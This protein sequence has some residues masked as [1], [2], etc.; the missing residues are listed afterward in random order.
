MPPLPFA[1][2][3]QLA[4]TPRAN[5]SVQKILDAAAKLFGKEGYDGASMGAV[6]KA[7]GVSKGLLHYHFRSKEHLLI[8]AGRASFRQLHARFSERF[9]RGEVGL[10]PALE[11]LDSLWAA[12]REMEGWAPFMV[13]T[14]AI[15]AQDGA[16]REHLQAFYTEANEHLAE[17]IRQV[18]A[19]DLSRL[20][21]PPERLALMIRTALEGLA[22]EL[23]HARTD[24]DYARVH[25]TYLDMR[26]MFA[27]SVL[28][29]DD[30]CQEG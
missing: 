24:E 23:A 8:E 10:E 6:A 17:G 22:T 11:A 12:L 21:M 18:F 5:R 26:T 2:S 29:P 1:S 9:G 7:A 27:G 13:E 16:V 25:R 20:R 4:L 3:V 28:C 19:D 14:M 15:A 30:G